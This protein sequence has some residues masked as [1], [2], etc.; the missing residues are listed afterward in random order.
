VVG[1][2][3]GVRR[4]DE[5][6]VEAVEDEDAVREG[7]GVV[8]VGRHVVEIGQMAS[9]DVVS[10]KA[11]VVPHFPAVPPRLRKRQS[12]SCFGLAAAELRFVEPVR[13]ARLA[14]SE[15]RLVVGLLVLRAGRLLLI[16]L[17]LP[18]YPC[19]HSA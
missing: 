16:D 19:C 5:E 7:I 14:H 6:A 3:L 1:H 11:V 8:V 15:P 12:G 2:W 10:S 18:V 4:G 9:Q 17:A 13:F